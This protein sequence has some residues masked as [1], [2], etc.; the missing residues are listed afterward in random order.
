MKRIFI[1]NKK[2][3]IGFIITVIVA[4]IATIN[5]NLNANREALSDIF[6]ANVEV[7]ATSETPSEVCQEFCRTSSGN[8]CELKGEFATLRCFNMTKKGIIAK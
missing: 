5:V 7:L 8:T 1:V 4:I 6:L 3:F 2:K